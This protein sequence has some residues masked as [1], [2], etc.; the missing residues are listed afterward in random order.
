MSGGSLDALR[1]MELIQYT[2]IHAHRF[3][4]IPSISFLYGV[5]IK[6]FRLCQIQDLIKSHLIWNGAKF[7]LILF[8]SPFIV[9]FL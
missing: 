9:F 4:S 8:Q 1:E 6:N 5:Q 2:Q 3:V 7:P